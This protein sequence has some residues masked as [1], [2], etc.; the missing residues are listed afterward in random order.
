VP[1]IITEPTAGSGGGAALLFF[2]KSAS[3]RQRQEEAPDEV[4]GLPPSIS[5]GFGFGTNKSSW[6]AG[7][8]HFGSWRKDSIRYL[9]VIA[10]TSLDLDLFVRDREFAYDLEG[11]FTQH[12]L[13]FRLFGSN[14]FLGPRY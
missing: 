1:I 14:F 5:F 2:H 8:G 10:Y 4:L 6:G 12:E 13:L 11:V 3:D 9:G 7:A